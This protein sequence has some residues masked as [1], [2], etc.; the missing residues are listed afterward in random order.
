MPPAA[1]PCR[2]ASVQTHRHQ[3][4]VATPTKAIPLRLAAGLGLGVGLL[5]AGVGCN[6]ALYRSRADHDVYSLLDEKLEDSTRPLPEFRIETDRRSRMFDPFNPDR[7]PMPEDDPISHQYMEVVDGKKHYPLWEINGRTNLSESPDWWQYLPLDERGV[8]VI[9]ADE[10]FRLALLHSP[11]YQQ[12]LETMYLSALDV[13]SERFLFDTQFFG[14]SQLGWATSGRNRPGN[15]GESR[16]ELSTGPF[17]RGR[18]PLSMQRRFATGADLV[19]GMANSI[20]WQM[21]GPS[22]QS[23]NSI[24]DFTF[25]Q[26]L[27]RQAGRDVVLERLTLAERTLLANVRTFERYRTGFYL[28][29]TVGRQAEQGPTRRGGLFG[30]AGLE[31]FTG[32]GGGFGRVGGF[33]GGAGLAALGGGGS[34]PSAG[35]FLGLLQQQLEI[36]NA[37]EN[38]ARLRDNLLRFEETLRELQTTMPAGL[39]SI[40]GQLLQVAQ[41]RQ[42]LFSAQAQLLNTRAAFEQSLDTF[43]RTLGLPPYLAVELRDPMLD[44]FNL[45]SP[46]LKQRRDEVARIRDRFGRINSQLLELSQAGEDPETEDP[47]RSIEMTDQVAQLIEEVLPAA[48]AAATIRYTLEEVDIPALEADIARLAAVVPQRVGQLRRLEAQYQRNKE[49][50]FNLLPIGNLD[51]SL[52]ETDELLA[53]PETLT[54]DLERLKGRLREYFTQ[55]VELRTGVREALEP[56]RSLTDRQRFDLLRD[57]VILKSQDI[58]ASLAEDIL[59]LQVLQARARTEAV[60]LTEIDLQPDEAVEIARQYRLD[61]MNARASLVDAWRSI[62][63]VADNLEGF[64]DVVF[65]GDVLNTRSSPLSLRSSTGSLRV[66]LQW[67]SPLTRLLERNQYRQILLE[68]QQAKRS[69]Y[70]YEDSVWQTMRALLRSIEASQINFELQRY[71]VRIAA[72]QITLNEDLRAIRENLGGAAGPTAARDSVSALQDLLNAQNNFLGVWVFYEVLRR[73]LDQDLGT[74]RVDGEGLWIDPG[75]ISR[76]MLGQV[77]QLLPANPLTL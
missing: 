24:L 4:G 33:G 27:L 3:S 46:E 36:E 61:W 45:I 7:P 69:Y 31:G 16:T 37:E 49:Q 51:G 43:K 72:Q 2:T 42:A 58:T 20:T 22:N 59:A 64:L 28:Q 44:R 29:V 15:A 9:D 13:S 63:L 35:G 26:P 76:D 23:A 60:V 57:G 6:R 10:A 30:G 14:G 66:G 34:V 74:I 54:G 53:L 47:F 12:Q 18:R 77:D 32:L 73:N 41:A 71:A 48:D 40:P 62:E 75:P 38:V 67:D 17:S 68:Y 5:V 25:I 1:D 19:V 11:V 8:L 21:S 55:L 52:F 39:E 56:Q 50:V 70:Q 65:S